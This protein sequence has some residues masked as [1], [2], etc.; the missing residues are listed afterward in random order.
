MANDD[1]AYIIAEV[2]GRLNRNDLDDPTASPAITTARKFIQARILYYQRE[3]FYASQFTDLSK[4][5]S[6]GSPWVDLLTGWNDLSM[7][8]IKQSGTQWI[9]LHG[10]VDY[11]SLVVQETQVTPTQSLPT[12]WARY[13]NPSTGLQAIR[14]YPTPNLVYPLEFTMDKPPAAP[15]ANAD[16][17]FWTQDA[18]EL[19]IE[20]AI[21]ALCKRQINNPMRG[22]TAQEAKNDELRSLFSKTL[23]ASGTIQIQPHW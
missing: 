5:T 21:E 18:A 8:R 10:P 22:Q 3:V 20:A 16:S 19:I 12:Q 4:S 17:N 2:T 14:L 1:Y 9:P 7:V 23:R 6:I 15:V 11:N 13:N